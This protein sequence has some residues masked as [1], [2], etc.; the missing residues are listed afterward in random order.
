MVA[1]VRPL[2][3]CAALVLA[4]ACDLVGSQEA[5]EPPA[6]P[7]T[8]SGTDETD[9]SAEP[10]EGHPNG[11]APPSE[12]ELVV[13]DGDP[14]LLEELGR[15]AAQVADLRGL[16]V[17]QP[18]HLDVVSEAEL[19]EVHRELR[20]EF[21]RDEER[22]ALREER[23][24]TLETLYL[25][26]EGVDL[27]EALDDLVEVGVLGLFSPR[28]ERA[29][30]VADDGELTPA[31]T[32][33]VAHELVHAIQHQH[34]GLDHLEDLEEPDEYFA[35]SSLIEGD[36]VFVE[37]AWVDAFL[38]DE[39]S[40]E[41]DATLAR[42]GIEAQAALETIPDYILLKQ[43]LP[44]QFGERF[45][46]ALLDEGGQERLDATLADPPRTSVEIYDPQLF[47]DGFTPRD[48]PPLHDPDGWEGFHAT[49][50]G[51]WQVDFFAFT[52]TPARSPIGQH[53]RGGE[54]RAWSDGDDGTAAAFSTTF[55]SDAAGTFCERLP[56]WYEEH[57]AATATDT[58][59][60]D[61]G[62]SR[63]ELSTDRGVVI[64]DCTSTD[65]RVAVAPDADVAAEILDGS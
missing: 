7:S 29:Y 65:V 41:R 32:A 17:L 42:L 39:E 51:A 59:G 48:A 31:V 47:L 15:I 3:A 58:T 23:Q 4:A 36:A 60:T 24:R 22:L 28:T 38:D 20:E 33:T 16:D 35:H 54:L 12:G 25:L 55:D 9:T 44:Y 46:T 1:I 45:V 64:V 14:Q 5:S 43:L 18:I 10:G 6:G 61:G 13:G 49:S 50:F 63:T 52:S 37:E 40:E 19:L 21:D 11:D 57:A 8:E 53:W 34:V 26:P 62:S 27:D 30:A 56:S 2:V